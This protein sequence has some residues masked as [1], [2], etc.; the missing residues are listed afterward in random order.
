[1]MLKIEGE[2]SRRQQR[3]ELIYLEMGVAKIRR[4]EAD[5]S[6]NVRDAG[7]GMRS[8]VQWG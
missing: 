7:E 3:L 1:M 2:E 6:E 5:V 8:R 4:G